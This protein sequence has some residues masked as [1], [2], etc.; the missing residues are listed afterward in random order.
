MSLT[1]IKQGMVVRIADQDNHNYF[2]KGV[3]LAVFHDFLP[4]K[5]YIRIS[6]ESGEVLKG[7]QPE[8]LTIE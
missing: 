5:V 6:L 8:H 1:D 3:V 2:K 7:F 4:G